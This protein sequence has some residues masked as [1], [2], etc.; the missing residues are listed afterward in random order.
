[1][2]MTA[3]QFWRE[4]DAWKEQ[5]LARLPEI[6]RKAVRRKYQALMKKSV[7]EANEYLSSLIEPLE[8]AIDIGADDDSLQTLAKECALKCSDFFATGSQF[9]QG[10]QFEPWD[11]CLALANSFNIRFPFEHDLNQQRARLLDDTWWLR[12]LRN[13]HAK[14][15][16]AA[17]RE[18][19][20]V[21]KKHDVYVSDD[22]LDRRRQQIRRNAELLAG[23]EMVN[24]HGEVMKLAD[25]ANAGMANQ[26]NRRAEL[27]TRITGFEELAVKYSHKATFITLTCPSRMHRMLS[28]GKENPKYDGTKPDEAQ[29]Y[30]THTWAKARALLAKYDVKYYGLRVAEP[31]HDGTPHWHIILFYDGKQSTLKKLKWHITQKFI[32]TDRDELGRDVSPRVLFKAIEPSKGTAAGYVIKY[33]AKNLGG[34]EG[35]RDD[36]VGEGSSSETNAERVEAWASTWRIRQFQQLGGHS[37]TTWR[38]LRRIDEK[39]M[40]GKSVPFVKAWQAAQKIHKK[41]ANFAKYIEAMGGLETPMRDSRF[42]VHYDVVTIRGRYG[43]APAFKV[44]GVGERHGRQVAHTNRAQWERV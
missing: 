42:K 44:L 34:I 32:E 20:I 5:K 15:R 11:K 28:T 7:R 8:G 25:I 9:G 31:H 40:E 26:A 22:T 33:V 21:H 14:A 36:E 41:K 3:Y 6:W 23:I 24:E 35:E 27:M 43:D 13:A 19:G 37:V 12:N 29:K 4:M 1:M 38:E 2:K 39:T 10:F 17:A 18:A 30:L 16:E